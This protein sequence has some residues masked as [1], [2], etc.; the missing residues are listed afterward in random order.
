MTTFRDTGQHHPYG[1]LEAFA[2]NALDPEEELAVTEHIE[3]CAGCA[4][5]ANDHLQTASALGRLILSQEP[6]ERLRARLFD[7]IDPPVPSVS[8]V[9]VSATRPP[10]RNWSGALSG[11]GSRWVRLFTPAFAVLAVVMIAVTIGL[12]V[13]I[14]GSIDDLQ[15]ENSRLQESLDQSIETSAGLSRSSDAVSQ[16]QDSLQR[17]QQTS[18]ALAQPGNKTVVLSAARPGVDAR[19]FLVVSEDGTAGLLMVSDLEPQQPDSVYHVWL[20]SGGQRYWAGEMEVDAQGNGAINL[21][22]GNP[23]QQ[24]DSIQLSRG[25]GVAAALAAPPGSIERAK[26]TVGM[27]GDTV[28]AAQLR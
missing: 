7:S 22:P 10:P 17:W 4:D 19:G 21:I 28:L 25:M 2:L 9:S 18:Y 27:V 20:T 5:I 13:R 26:A 23:L 15:S 3:R 6:P 24:Y 11:P 8:L 14:S 16:M 12:N 1:L